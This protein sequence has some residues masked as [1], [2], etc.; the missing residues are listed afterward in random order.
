MF[1][2]KLGLLEKAYD[3]GWWLNTDDLLKFLI[4]LSLISS[5]Q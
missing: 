5:A 2:Q 4:L 1:V 3:N